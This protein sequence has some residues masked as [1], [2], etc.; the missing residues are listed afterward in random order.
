MYS[1]SPLKK[2]DLKIILIISLFTAA[3]MT[4][5]HQKSKSGEADKNVNARQLA[6]Q[7]LSENKLDDAVAAFQQAI[8]IN[9]DDTLSYIGL[10][11]LYLLQKNYDAAEKLCKHALKV[12]PGNINLK[13]FLAEAYV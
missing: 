4:G 5:C 7:Y 12:Q 11:R 1:F 10:S 8:K 6:L 13:L 3:L 9:P 2:R